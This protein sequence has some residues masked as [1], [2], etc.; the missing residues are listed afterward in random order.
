M[1]CRYNLKMPQPGK[2]RYLKIAT[3]VV[4]LALAAAYF[5]LV[6]AQFSVTGKPSMDMLLLMAVLNLVL[7]L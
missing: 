3:P 7:Y 6:D 1:T 2:N 5:L 4:I